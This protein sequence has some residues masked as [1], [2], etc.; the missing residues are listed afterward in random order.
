MKALKTNANDPNTWNQVSS[1][2]RMSDYDR[3]NENRDFIDRVKAAQSNKAD[4][5]SQNSN[6]KR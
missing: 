6:Q 1:K 2:I 4:P 3:Q 5:K